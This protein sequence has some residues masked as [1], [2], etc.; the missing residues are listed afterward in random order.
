[1]D[2]L[3]ILR[4]IW[5][6]RASLTGPSSLNLTQVKDSDQGWYECK[7][8]FLNRPAETPANGSWVLLDVQAPPHFKI[9]PPDVIYVKTGDSL[10]LSCEA[11]GTPSPAII[12]LKDKFLLE[13]S[14]NLKIEPNELRIRNI[15]QGDIGDYTC[16][17]KNN[18][19]AVST[20]SRVIVAGPAVIT[21]PPRNL[22]K[23][24]GDKAEFICEAKALPSNFTFKWFREG[25]EI[26]AINWLES[27]STVKRDGTLVINPTSADDSGKYSCEVSNGIGPSDSTSAFLSVEYPA[28]VTYSPTIQFLPT[29][30][31]GIVRCFIQANP[32]FQFITW[33]KD[34]RPFDPNA[35]PGVTTLNNG[36]LLFARV[37]N[38]L[39]GRYRCTPYNIHGTAG[40]S[41][42]MEVLVRGMFSCC[43]PSSLSLSSLLS[44]Y[45][46]WRYDD[47]E[48]RTIPP[49]H[50]MW[51]RRPQTV[52]IPLMVSDDVHSILLIKSLDTMRHPSS[53]TS[54]QVS[55]SWGR[56]LFRS[57][58]SLSL[59]FARNL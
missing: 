55:S 51:T 23:L 5:R 9:K 20:T 6:Q 35:T 37:S 34:R 16:Q 36:S 28:R 14:G 48:F 3:L 24:E 21:G 49:T 54:S 15:Q 58:S 19:G 59:L 42:P 50:N 38:E 43:Q 22:T 39:Q 1:M 2:I 10:S 41:N 40:T 11:F 53:E 47:P 32:P 7:V 25:I 8:Y 4:R 30:L 46:R 26:S 17:A 45:P 33:T 27:R 52:L 57:W 29:G 56:I 13:E 44:H 12:W 31:S 18:E